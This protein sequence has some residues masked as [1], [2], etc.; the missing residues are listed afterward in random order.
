[1]R[2]KVIF[3]FFLLV[4]CTRGA[5]A[6]AGIV[7]GD[8][9]DKGCIPQYKGF[10]S[11]DLPFLTYRAALGTGTRHESDEFYAVILESVK[12]AS[13]TNRKGCVFVSESKRLAIQRQFPGNKVF[14]SRNACAGTIVLYDS[15]NH[16]FNFMAIY[17]GDTEDQAAGILLKAKRRYPQANIRK[18]RV[19][20][21]FADQ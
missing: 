3:I 13:I 17:A 21:D 14:S 2:T 18:M 8:P 20:L 6:Q 9:K 11:F 19:I 16:D 10:E 1:M 12:A 4:L 15:V 5:H 7:C